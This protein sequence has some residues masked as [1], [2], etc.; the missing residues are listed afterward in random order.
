MTAASTPTTSTARSGAGQG[1][2]AD[3]EGATGGGGIGAAVGGHGAT[4]GDQSG[5]GGA[6]VGAGEGNYLQLVLLLMSRMRSCCF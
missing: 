3:P 2:I 4:G 1:S 6:G 5:P